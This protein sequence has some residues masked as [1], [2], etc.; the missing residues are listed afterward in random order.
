MS[1]KHRA[2]VPALIPTKSEAFNGP[3]ERPYTCDG[4]GSYHGGVNESIACLRREL[5]RAR[6]HLLQHHAWCPYLAG[7]VPGVYPAPEKGSAVKP[8]SMPHAGG[9]FDCPF[10]GDRRGTCGHARKR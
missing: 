10:C 4:C 5:A 9:G 2:V 3:T 6:L 1:A 8:T 7:F